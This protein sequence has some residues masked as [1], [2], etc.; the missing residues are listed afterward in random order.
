MHTCQ[1]QI[2]LQLLRMNRCNRRNGLHFYNDFAID[3][4]VRTKSQVE[5]HILIN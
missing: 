2:R 1:T 5:L 3:N 4:D